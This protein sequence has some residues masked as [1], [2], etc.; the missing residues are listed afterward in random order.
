MSSASLPVCRN[1]KIH[2][3]QSQKMLHNETERKSFCKQRVID[4]MPLE[5]G[6]Q[7]VLLQDTP[8]RWI[9]QVCC[10]KLILNNAAAQRNGSNEVSPSQLGRMESLKDA[11][12]W[13]RSHVRGLGVSIHSCSCLNWKNSTDQEKKQKNSLSYPSNLMNTEFTCLE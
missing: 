6:L 1:V 10:F 5:F 13:K 4:H 2:A 8:E 11:E 12:L 9:W 7:R 3:S